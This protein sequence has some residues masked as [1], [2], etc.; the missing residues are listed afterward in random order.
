MGLVSLFFLQ[1]SSAEDFV[2][3]AECTGKS[4]DQRSNI[5]AV[6]F[7]HTQARYGTIFLSE[8]SGTDTIYRMSITDISYHD[9]DGGYPHVHNNN[10]GMDFW[11]SDEDPSYVQVTVGG[12]VFTNDLKCLYRSI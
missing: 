3:M 1:I 8:K 2:V 11:I 6:I 9:S 7:Q 10:F 4:L 12:K 5:E